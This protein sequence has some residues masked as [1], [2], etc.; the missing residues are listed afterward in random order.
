[1]GVSSLKGG[2]YAPPLTEEMIENCQHNK[3]KHTSS[4]YHDA[5]SNRDFTFSHGEN[6]TL[7]SR[8]KKKNRKSK[9]MSA[10]QLSE[11]MVPSKP[12]NGYSGELPRIHVDE[13][14]IY[15]SSTLPTKSRRSRNQRPKSMLDQFSENSFHSQVEWADQQDE[16]EN[17]SSMPRQ[18]NRKVKVATHSLEEDEYLA[19]ELG[20]SLV[21]MNE[22]SKNTESHLTAYT[23]MPRLPRDYGIYGD[24]DI[25][26]DN[27]YSPSIIEP[28]AP[29]RKAQKMGLA[30]RSKSLGTMVGSES[31]SQQQ[32]NMAL[33]RSL[34]EA[35]LVRE[36][37][38]SSS[39]TPEDDS[40][41]NSR[42]N[43]ST[44]NHAVEPVNPPP[45][46]VKHNVWN[47]SQSDLSVADLHTAEDGGRRQEL[48]KKRKESKRQLVER[49][50]K[51]NEAIKQKKKNSLRDSLRNIFFRKR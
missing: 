10:S 7:P 50:N 41:P 20:Q 25:I 3:Q 15:E 46:R 17:Y 32:I 43:S 42:P 49:L 2:K 9:T 35:Q 14:N 22:A 11:N 47:E 34:T 16:D 26:E 29:T 44:R 4:T 33:A 21:N 36:S 45:E 8:G 48:M 23:S 38:R 51:G 5:Y 30:H 1:M 19:Y 18:K 13:A 12:P 27:D 39:S 28:E 24:E 6:A 37:K 40:R 31:P